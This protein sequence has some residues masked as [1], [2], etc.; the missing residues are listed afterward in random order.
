[1]D[2]GEVDTKGHSP[3]VRLALKEMQPAMGRG[4]WCGWL[5]SH[6]G[7][8]PA[9]GLCDFQCGGFCSA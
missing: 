3:V 2:T 9:L 5:G 8:V 1:M 6:L 4:W 7:G